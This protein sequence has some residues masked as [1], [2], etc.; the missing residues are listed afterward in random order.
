MYT[1][2]K[3]ENV[4][5]RD[6]L[7]D[8]G[9]DGRIILKRNMACKSGVDSSGSLPFMKPKVHF[10]FHKTLPMVPILNQTFPAIFF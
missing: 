7:G 4:T 6:H 2:V 1:K 3:P 9:T 10:H 8:L 5:G